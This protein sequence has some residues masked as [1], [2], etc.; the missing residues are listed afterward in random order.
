MNKISVAGIVGLGFL[1]AGCTST[2]RIQELIGA[3]HQSYTSKL[4]A[5]DSAIASLQQSA[6]KLQKGIERNHAELLGLKTRVDAMLAQLKLIQSY[7]DSAKMMSAANTVKISNLTER[8]EESVRAFEQSIDRIDAVDKLQEEQLV[9]HCQMLIDS[10]TEVMDAL[11]SGG[12]SAVDDVPLEIDE[13]IEI[14]APDTT[15]VESR[16]VLDS[17]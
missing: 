11:A 16:A 12:S 6:T 3:S 17:E 7:A 10:A 15:P 1:L 4:A 13:P 5:H 8:F 14:V 2:S 9:N